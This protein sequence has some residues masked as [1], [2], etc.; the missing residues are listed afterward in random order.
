MTVTEELIKSIQQC[1]GQIVQNIQ[2]ATIALYSAHNL[3]AKMQTA[4]TDW[5]RNEIIKEGEKALKEMKEIM[6]YR[7]LAEGNDGVKQTAAG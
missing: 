2:L 6:G 4:K 5:E 1:T 7:D 3:A